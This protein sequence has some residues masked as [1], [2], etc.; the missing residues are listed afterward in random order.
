MNKNI[1]T[2]KGNTFIASV[3]LVLRINQSTNFVSI[4]MIF[5]QF[6]KLRKYFFTMKGIT[7]R[8]AM[9]FYWKAI[10]RVF[11]PFLGV[12]PRSSC[13]VVFCA[14]ECAMPFMH[15][16]D[17]IIGLFHGDGMVNDCVLIFWWR[18]ENTSKECRR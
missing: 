14:I 12:D 4:R 18:N 6:S 10:L 5:I 16:Y 15:F 11:F 2:F 17:V 13:I 3:V 7:E 8:R 9:W 1:Q